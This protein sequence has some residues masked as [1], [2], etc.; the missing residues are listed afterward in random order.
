[1]S[2]LIVVGFDSETKA[3]EVLTKLGKLQKS[4]L[5]DLEDA[6]VVIKEH[7]TRRLLPSN[8]YLI[9]ASFGTF[10]DVLVILAIA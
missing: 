3:D 5:I 10:S 4:H 2:D 6:A 1:M 9:A 7:K 8:D